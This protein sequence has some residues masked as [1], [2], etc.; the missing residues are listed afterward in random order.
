MATDY[1]TLRNDALAN[2]EQLLNLWKIEYQKVGDYE[3]DFKNPT[4]E[5]RNF[6]ACR[7]NILK[8]IGS[9]FALRTFNEDDFKI[10]GASFDK[11]DFAPMS[12]E[13]QERQAG[14]D[15]IGLV[16]RI[17]RLPSYR[18][19]AELLRKHIILLRSKGDLQD[20][21]EATKEREDTIARRN[22]FMIKRVT[23]VWGYCKSVRGS[24]A[25]NYLYNRA[26]ENTADEPN[27][28]FHPR[29]K[30]KELDKMMPALVFKVAKSPQD[31]ITALHRIYLTMDG[32]YKADLVNN[33]MAYGPIKGCGIWFGA[34]GPKLYIAEGPENALSLREAGCDFVVSTVYSTNFS[35][36]TIPNIV[37]FIVMAIDNDPAGIANATK[38]AREYS[39][40]QKVPCKVIK[41]K[42]GE[43]WNSALMKDKG[44]TNA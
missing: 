32:A 9:D 35:N 1:T 30:N 37:E 5:D 43:D 44:R 25:E 42:P 4:R 12:T 21:T 36:L 20:S 40:E 34:P 3:Y 17:N 27:M 2:F 19:A 18:E 23:Q 28:R 16:Q 14:F 10:L 26:I 41:P 22:L 8:N 15:I 29:I 7:F 13:N 39:V 38:A 11:N 24:I 33:K 31:E 6:G